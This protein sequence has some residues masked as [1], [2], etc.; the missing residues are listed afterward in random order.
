MLLSMKL[1]KGEMIA[2]IV[3]AG[4]A[5]AVAAVAGFVVGMLIYGV[6]LRDMGGDIG[7]KSL[8]L[9]S[10]APAVVFA[11]VAFI[12]TYLKMTTYTDPPDER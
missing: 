6:M 2:A 11:I 3:A 7:F 5:A 8:P 10:G 4:I 1:A 12:V 9:M